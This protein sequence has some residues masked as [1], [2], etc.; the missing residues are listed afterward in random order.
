MI[1]SNYKF[2]FLHI[3]KTAGTSIEKVFGG[4][5]AKHKTIRK[6]FRDLSRDQIDSYFRFTFIRNPYD[7]IVSLYNYLKAEVSE[8][9]EFDRWIEETVCVTM[10][11]RRNMNNARRH[12]ATYHEWLGD[13]SMMDTFFIGRFENL[14][15]DFDRVCD[16]IQHD[17]VTLPHEL[18]YKCSNKRHYSTYY[19]DHTRDLITTKYQQDLDTF[20]YSYDEN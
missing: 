13:K 5:R 1:N 7:R 20:N 8:F 17:K 6:M 4:C 15:R 10:N 18:K 14:Q 11:E 12:F 9:P 16:I 2:I 19:T 3:P